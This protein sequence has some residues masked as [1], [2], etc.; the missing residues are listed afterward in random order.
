MSIKYYLGCLT[1]WI[2]TKH[3]FS[4]VLLS[5]HQF[6]LN[7]FFWTFPSLFNFNRCETQKKFFQ[8]FFIFFLF[9][10]LNSHKKIVSR[11]PAASLDSYAHYTHDIFTFLF[12]WRW[13]SFAWWLKKGSFIDRKATALFTHSRKS[14]ACLNGSIS[15]TRNRWWRQKKEKK[16]NGREWKSV[17]IEGFFFHLWI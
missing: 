2:E 17:V 4:L 8:L 1:V 13:Q 11:F 3:N 5:Q 12:Q 15:W 10:I 16:W 14:V 7:F 6:F 9:L